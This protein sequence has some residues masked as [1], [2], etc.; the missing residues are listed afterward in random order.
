M[1]AVTA[2]GVQCDQSVCR[3]LAT[4][5]WVLLGIVDSIS[6]HLGSS[7]V[8]NELKVLQP[9]RLLALKACCLEKKVMLTQSMCHICNSQQR[10][11]CSGSHRFYILNKMIGFEIC[12]FISTIKIILNSISVDDTHQ[13]CISMFSTWEISSKGR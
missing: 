5:L 4:S 11:L 6:W 1:Q 2:H 3:C 10:E 8:H 13:C 12:I 7:V 9:L